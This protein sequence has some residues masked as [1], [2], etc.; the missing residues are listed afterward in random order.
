MT[1]ISAAWRASRKLSCADL[2]QVIS[3]LGIGETNPDRDRPFFVADPEVLFQE[4]DE[5]LDL[6]LLGPR[7]EEPGP[8][9]VLPPQQAGPGSSATA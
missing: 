7:A 3:E 4:A 6:F 2:D 5:C 8:Q 9:G 1:E